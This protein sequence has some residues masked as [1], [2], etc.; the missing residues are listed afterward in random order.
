MSFELHPRLAEDTLE[1]GELPLCRVLLMN[2]LTYPWCILVPQRTA[3]R[4]IHHLAAADQLQL[5]QEISGVAAAMESAFKADKMNIAALGNVVPQLHV[6]IIAR[7]EADPVW[8][9]PVWGKLP[10]RP[11]PLADRKQRIAKMHTAF[12]TLNGFSAS[13]RSLS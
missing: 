7:F 11:Y 10:P 6:H 8:P 3:T 9:A 2:D 1:V 12:E 5:L 13:T 4:E